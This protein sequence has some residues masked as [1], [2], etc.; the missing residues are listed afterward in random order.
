MPADL[1]M[2]NY[3]IT[4]Q[5]TTSIEPHCRIKLPGKG[6]KSFAAEPMN[7]HFHLSCPDNQ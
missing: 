2:L 1:M 4:I 6:F 7:T 5:N 3:K